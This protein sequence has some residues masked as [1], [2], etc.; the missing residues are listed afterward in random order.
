MS[1]I[2]GK[3]LPES[4]DDDSKIFDDDNSSEDDNKGEPDDLNDSQWKYASNADIKPDQVSKG[5][6]S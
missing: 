6:L 2:S 1:S 3:I 5:R 4:F